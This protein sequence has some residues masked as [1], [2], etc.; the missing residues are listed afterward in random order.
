MIFVSQHR[1]LKNRESAINVITHRF[2]NCFERLTACSSSSIRFP[3]EKLTFLKWNKNFFFLL[4]LF[5]PK[6]WFSKWYKIFVHSDWSRYPNSSFQIVTGFFSTINISIVS[7]KPARMHSVEPVF[8]FVSPDN[9]SY[10]F[11]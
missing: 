1:G 3:M 9:Y 11:I 10:C 6:C 5:P 2:S 4:F 7:F 8:F